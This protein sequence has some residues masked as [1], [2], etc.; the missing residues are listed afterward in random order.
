MVKTEV[1]QNS[2]SK[3]SSKTRLRM[4]DKLV[5]VSL[6]GWKRISHKKNAIYSFTHS[7]RVGEKKSPG[8]EDNMAE[9]ID[10]SSSVYSKSMKT[11]LRRRQTK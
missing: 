9:M 4:H 7:E 1:A 6:L 11:V 5:Y 10:H 2:Y 3:V 8:E